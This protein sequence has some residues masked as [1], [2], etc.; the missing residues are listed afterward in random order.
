MKVI[1]LPITMI[2]HLIITKRSCPYIFGIFVLFLFIQEIQSQDTIRH[3]IDSLYELDYDQLSQKFNTIRKD[4]LLYKKYAKIYLEKAKLEG[5]IIKQSDGFYLLGLISKESI[6]IRYADSIV[7]LTKE[8]EDFVY[9][10]RGHLLKARNLGR[11]QSYPEALDELIKANHYA[12]KNGN[13]DQKF[14][15]KYF[16]GVLKINLG[17]LQ[18]SLDQYK[19]T[20]AY[21]K[22]K[23]EEN[24]KYNQDYLK[25]LFALGN[26]YTRLKKNDSAYYFMKKGMQLALKLND[27]I[28]YG[29]FLLS[30]GII[31]YQKKD[32]PSSTDSLLKFKKKFK[33]KIK[34]ANIA[35]ADLYLG[36]NYYENNNTEKAIEYLQ[37]VDSISAIQLRSCY[38]LLLKIYKSKNNIEKQVEYID[39]ILKTDSI[40]NRDFKYLYKN[41]EKEYSTPS[42][43]LEKE[44]IINSLEANK[45]NNRIQISLLIIALSLISSILF[46]NNRKRKIYKSRFLKLY[47]EQ[48]VI[49]DSEKGD[50]N[51][52]PRDIGIPEELIDNI[53]NKLET[54]EKNKGYLSSGLTIAKLAKTFETNSRYLSKVINIFKEKSFS[55]YLNDLRI[56]YAIEELKQNEKFRK[57]TI[58][59]IANE[60][61]FNSSEVFSKLFYKK[62]GIYPSFFL[63]ELKKTL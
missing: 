6:A 31:N 39:K 59:A 5:D 49:V 42:L 58:K 2:F 57:Y 1:Y 40:I 9:P 38:E 27:S 53:L 20:I 3:Q 30:S 55:N 7:N 8:I 47:D 48:N 41:I 14:K 54:F 34:D 12:T 15:I 10:A 56:K 63:K 24:N 36:K 43:I 37:K 23:Y 4:T 19:S 52:N 26:G 44:Q 33:Y 11:I 62:T 29:Y 13:I 22:K 46:Y 21:Y 16:I 17:E 60:I 25:S 45:K 28:Y 35:I 61:G 32:Y 51:Q 18:A 50:T